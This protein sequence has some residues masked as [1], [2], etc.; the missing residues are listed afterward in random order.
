MFDH[1][2]P[3]EQVK[4]L[5]KIH[6][7]SM[8]YL[9]RQTGISKQNISNWLKRDN[10]HSPSDPGAWDK[11]LAALGA[12]DLDRPRPVVENP[13]VPVIRFA[14][15]VPA[16]EW[17]DPLASE[18]M[19]EV[20]LRFVHNQRFAAKVI[21]DSCFPALVQG[22]VTIWHT[23]PNPPYGRIVIA[24]R[25]GD[26]D[27]T[28]KE[29]HYDQTVLRPILK[30]VNPKYSAPPDGDGWGV[31][32]YLVGLIRE[33]SEGIEESYYNKRGF[34]AKQLIRISSSLFVEII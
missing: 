10:P 6:S 4:K 13:F 28:V 15:N 11:L 25:K 16:G 24:Q 19:M 29:L 1:E 23:D 14:G 12:T 22:D 33:D 2:G 27:C 34:T 7:R 3:R 8:S 17:G 20:D 5:L 32:G 9:E 30:P 21:G 18:E 26:H 31:I